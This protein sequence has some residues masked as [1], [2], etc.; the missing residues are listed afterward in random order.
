MLYFSFPHY[1]K[2]RAKIHNIFHI[3]KRMGKKNDIIQKFLRMRPN[4]VFLSPLKSQIG[5][6]GQKREKRKKQKKTFLL[7]HV[8]LFKYLCTR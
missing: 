1:A 6:G 3:R 5:N 4:F 7:A 2:K 8:N